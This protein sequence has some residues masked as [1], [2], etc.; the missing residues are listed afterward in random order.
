[1]YRQQLEAVKVTKSLSAVTIAD[2]NAAE[3]DRTPFRAASG[4]KE[5]GRGKDKL[6]REKAVN[7][8]QVRGTGPD[9]RIVERD[10][11]AFL[12][13]QFKATPVAA[14]KAAELGV[15]LAQIS[16]SGVSGRIMG[17]DVPEL[18]VPAAATLA[19][20]WWPGSGEELA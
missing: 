3:T 8:A 9:G 2:W 16:G 17:R 4:H 13:R 7:L 11:Q 14:K 10:V 15:D 5:D 12:A 19:P 6:A 20:A 1:M 18:A